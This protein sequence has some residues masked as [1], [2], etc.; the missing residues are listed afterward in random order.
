MDE[1]EKYE[2]DIVLLKQN[3]QDRQKGEEFKL[4]ELYTEWGA[5]N[6]KTRAGKKFKELVNNEQIPNVCLVGKDSSNQN[7]YKKY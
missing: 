5:I 6:R 3:I 1:L 2:I 7:I 4:K